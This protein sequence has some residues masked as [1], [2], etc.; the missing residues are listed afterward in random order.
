[1]YN[2]LALQ[3]TN[4]SQDVDKSVGLSSL[5]SIRCICNEN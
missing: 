4:S 5:Y 1:M 2:V 3:A